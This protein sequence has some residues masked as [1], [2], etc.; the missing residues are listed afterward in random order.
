MNTTTAEP[1]ASS[2]TLPAAAFDSMHTLPAA[3][4]DSINGLLTSMT[5]LLTA[6]LFLTGLALAI[7]S[8][9]GKRTMVAAI[10]SG[11]AMILAVGLFVAAPTVT[12]SVSDQ[13]EDDFGESDGNAPVD[14]MFGDANK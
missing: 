5:G 3:A 1:A 13:L 14:S 9:L 11:I 2:H 6:A 12:G 7:M 4:F 10:S 8:A